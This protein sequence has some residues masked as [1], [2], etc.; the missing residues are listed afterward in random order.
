MSDVSQPSTIVQLTQAAA[1]TL[2]SF[3]TDAVT[4]PFNAELLAVTANAAVAPTVANATYDVFAVAAGGTYPG[5]TIY[6]G[7]VATLAQAITSSQTVIYVSQ[8][9]GQP[10][11]VV[12]QIIGIG[13]EILQVTAN[14]SGAAGQVGVGGGTAQTYSGG[15][16]SA[17]NDPNLLALTV[18]RGYL[19]STAAVG[20]VNANVKTIVPTL[21]FA[22]SGS[23]NT[24]T[25]IYKP[26]S[27]IISAGTTLT[28]KCTI[29]GTA[30]STGNSFSF[31]FAKR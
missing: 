15:T 4:L 31:H 10:P 29:L 20:A 1:F 28:L 2:N 25:A 9:V 12:N 23:V 8:I 26:S 14:E 21:P 13:T 11:I 7:N 22:A 24:G 18:T 3:S 30:G 16:V 19:G 27:P 5:A 6:G 17:I